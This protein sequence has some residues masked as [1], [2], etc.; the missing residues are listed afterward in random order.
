MI[1]APAITATCM[2]LLGLAPNS[3]ILIAILLTSG[4]GVSLFHVPAPVLI[5]DVAGNRLGKGMSFFMLGGE[6]ARSLGPI[7]IIGAVSLWG[8][9][10]T[11]NLIPVGLIATFIL[12]WRL[13]DITVYKSSDKAKKEM[14]L[15]QSFKKHLPF[16]AYT[17]GV[18]FLTSLIKGALT[19][20]L[21]LYLTEKGSS[22]W[23]AGISLSIIQLS[24]AVGTFTSGT[25]SDKIG[26]RLSLL[27]MVIVSPILMVMFVYFHQTLV[28][29]LLL[30]I[31]FFLFAYTPVLLAIVNELDTAHPSFLNGIFMTVNF[32]FSAL[33]MLLV[34]ILSDYIGLDNT[35][36]LTAAVCLLSIP[37]VILITKK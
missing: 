23:L 14:G 22:L 16:F 25:L 1:I 34:G 8:L 36:L 31:G 2:S 37:F 33:G 4:I 19:N 26:R 15:N 30:F 9:E 10:G 17:S 32:V 27:I 24:G 21:P 12:Y 18:V 3:I 6:L 11:Y 7:I 13:K 35:Y 28:I 20:F 29:P 5:K